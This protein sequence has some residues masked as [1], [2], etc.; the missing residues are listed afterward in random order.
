MA[1][2]H[3]LDFIVKHFLVTDIMV[4][5]LIYQMILYNQ[6]KNTKALTL[7][8]WQTQMV[9]DK[10]DI[11]FKKFV[12]KLSASLLLSSRNFEISTINSQ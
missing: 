11:D 9:K 3:K 4:N 7:K 1:S 6:R 2:L 12:Q 8:N 5:R 10:D